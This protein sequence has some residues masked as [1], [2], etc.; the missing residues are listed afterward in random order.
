MS[1]LTSV[2]QRATALGGGEGGGSDSGAVIAS[3][4]LLWGRPSKAHHSSEAMLAAIVSFTFVG[5][6]VVAIASGGNMEH[7]QRWRKW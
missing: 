2:L 3:R 5:A 7:G 4:R 1:A 6:A